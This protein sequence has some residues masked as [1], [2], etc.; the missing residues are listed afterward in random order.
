MLLVG[1]LVIAP[2]FAFE[3]FWNF[4]LQIVV[5]VTLTIMGALTLLLLPFIKGG[6]LGL[7]WHHGLKRF[8]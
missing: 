3:F 8:R 1:H 7:I 5:P 2:M 6:F 4:P